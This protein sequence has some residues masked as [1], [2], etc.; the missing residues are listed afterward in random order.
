[1]RFL[2]GEKKVSAIQEFN[3]FY[4]DILATGLFSVIASYQ[5]FLAQLLKLFSYS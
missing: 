1:M 5:N 2:Q 4:T 3:F